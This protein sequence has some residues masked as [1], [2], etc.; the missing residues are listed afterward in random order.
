MKKTNRREALK[1][2]ALGSFALSTAGSLSC[3]EDMNED[4]KTGSHRFKGNVNHSVCQWT[5]NFLPLDDLCQVVKKIGFNAIDLIAP[6]DWPTLQKYGIYSSMC[7]IGGKVSLTEG[8][9]DKKF[10]EQLVKDYQEVIPLM[11]KAGY[12]NVICFSGN[13]NGMDDETGLRNCAEGIKQFIG[14]AEK[15]NLMVQM[16]LLNSKVNHKDYM[17][18]KTPWGVE[19]V[20]RVGSPNFKLL[21]DIYHMQIDEGDVI[22]TIKDNKD[23][24]GHYHTGGVPGR[25]IIDESQELYYPAIMKAILETGFTD[26]VAQEFIPLGNSNDEKVAQLK[27]AVKICDV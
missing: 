26:Y 14:L 23:Y 5:Y 27:K 20:K 24:I 11:V 3:A 7:Y 12:K 8:F 16:E 4:H 18:D 9:N 17:C 10:H 1:N 6:K 22:R 2:L 19:L 15:N 21:Y 13:R 25:N